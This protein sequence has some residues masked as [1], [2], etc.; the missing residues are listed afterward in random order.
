LSR[1]VSPVGPSAF[2][3]ETISLTVISPELYHEGGRLH[4]RDAGLSLPPGGC[5]FAKPGNLLIIMI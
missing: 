5:G 2:R 4:K 1:R 3:M